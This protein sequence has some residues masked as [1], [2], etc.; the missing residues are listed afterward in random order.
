LEKH[1]CDSISAKQQ[2]SI[3][4]YRAFNNLKLNY[5]YVAGLDFEKISQD[6]LL[7]N[8][9]LLLQSYGSFLEKKYHRS[10]LYANNCAHY[11]TDTLK[12]IKWMLEYSAAIFSKKNQVI[13]SLNHFINNTY[14]YADRFERLYNVNEDYNKIKNKSPFVAGVLS[15]IFPGTGHLYN[16]NTSRFWGAITPLVLVG[17]I[18]AESIKSTGFTSAYTLGFGTV[19]SAFYISN[20]WG[21]V[22]G[23]KAKNKNAK[24][25]LH[26]QVVDIISAP[27]FSIY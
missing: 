3:Y 2:D 4:F 25:N 22:L 10:W 8:K 5:T 23:N 16:G 19:W 26:N 12:N 18:T 20:I 11:P 6:T 17:I 27:V 13:D 9:A 15:S 24:E 7:K 1:P 21:S 14:I